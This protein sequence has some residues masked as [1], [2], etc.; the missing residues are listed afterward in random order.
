VYSTNVLGSTS[1][2][3]LPR[4]LTPAS[5]R[6]VGC[7]PSKLNEPSGLA[8]RQA[9]SA[10]FSGGRDS[11]STSSP[12]SALA[13][14]SPAATQNGKRGFTA[15]SSPPSAGPSTNPSPNAAPS[16]PNPAARFSGGATSA[17]YAPAVEMLAAVIPE[18]TR[19]AN[20]QPSVGA[21]AI[22]T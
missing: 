9:R 4:K 20:N 17:M 7:E 5:P 16:S 11:G 2:A 19:P 18:I 21:S 15:P 12:Y 22:I 1:C 13:K 8:R 14:L 10:R 6:R 3:R